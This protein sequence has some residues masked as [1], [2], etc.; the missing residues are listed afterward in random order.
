LAR[1]DHGSKAGSRVVALKARLTSTSAADGGREGRPDGVWSGYRRV[2]GKR[3]FMLLWAGQAVSWFGDSLYFVS[4]LWLVQ[5]MTGSRAM[6]GAVAACRTVP[7]LLQVLTGAL[8]DRSDRRRMM[9]C[10]DLPGP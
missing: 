1:D 4:L 2:L 6:M 9:L 8:V 7:Q 10:A 5:E 3:N